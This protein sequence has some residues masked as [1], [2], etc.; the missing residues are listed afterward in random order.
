MIVIKINSFFMNIMFKHIYLNF[1]V[2]SFINKEMVTYIQL[3]TYKFGLV[4][5]MVNLVF[6]AFISEKLSQRHLMKGTYNTVSETD[7]I[8]NEMIKTCVNIFLP[9]LKKLSNSIFSSGFYP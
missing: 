9:C 4:Y 7:S 3:H 6:Y 8:R 5:N 1:G 2:I